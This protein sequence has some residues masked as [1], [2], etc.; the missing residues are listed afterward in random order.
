MEQVMAPKLT[1]TR[2]LILFICHASVQLEVCW[3]NTQLATLLN[4]VDGFGF[5]QSLPVVFAKVITGLQK[6]VR[7]D[8]SF[9][10]YGLYCCWLLSWVGLGFFLFWWG[11]WYFIFFLTIVL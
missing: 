11:F 5:A 6:L 1:C 4:C 7:K 2:H 9:C 10:S 8:L 3:M